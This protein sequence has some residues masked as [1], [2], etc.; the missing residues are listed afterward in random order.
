MGQR[1][2]RRQVQSGRDGDARPP[3]PKPI[4]TAPPA[5]GPTPSSFDD[6]RG[7]MRDVRDRQRQ[8]RA[9]INAARRI[10]SKWIVIMSVALS[11]PL[12]AAFLLHRVIPEDQR[13][14]YILIA[15][16][17]A[18]MITFQSVI[19]AMYRAAVAFVAGDPAAAHLQGRPHKFMLR[20]LRH[21]ILR[22][23]DFTGRWTVACL[24]WAV[25]YWGVIQ[26]ISQLFS[27]DPIDLG[28]LKRNYVDV[29]LLAGPIVGV[30][31]WTGDTAIREG[32]EYHRRQLARSG[33][34]LVKM[35]MSRGVNSVV[36]KSFV[37][38]VRLVV[39]VLFARL[40]VG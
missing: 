10:V 16:A 28:E 21:E 15:V 36:S 40:L 25:T 39:F 13:D 38:V 35:M 31:W 7:V 3:R 32:S 17:A 22:A 6:V 12:W 18:V 37:F 29:A 8:N 33:N 34:R 20:E 23:S 4:P 11:L 2:R 9:D 14:R 5:G 19:A 24:F 26:M 30:I 27:N 1:S